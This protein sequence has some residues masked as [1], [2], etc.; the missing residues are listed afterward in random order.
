MN[1]PDQT[2]SKLTLA[3]FLERN[4]QIK[5]STKAFSRGAYIDFATP[6]YWVQ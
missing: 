2:I 5:K 4:F 6:Y 3:E 1:S